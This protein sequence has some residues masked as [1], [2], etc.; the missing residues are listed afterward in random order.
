M[1]S[2]AKFLSWRSGS[3]I[4]FIS[5]WRV[6]R[7]SRTKQKRHRSPTCWEDGKAVFSKMHLR[8]SWDFSAFG[9]WKHKSS[10]REGKLLT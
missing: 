2:E 9:T 3:S 7:A 6:F 4:F 10:L 8:K 1:C 5:D